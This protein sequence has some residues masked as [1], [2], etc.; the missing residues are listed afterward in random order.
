MRIQQ[1]A[2]EGKFNY[3]VVY[4]PPARDCV[5]IE[6]LTANVDAFNTGEGLNIL[7]PG[8]SIDGTITVSLT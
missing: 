8:H 4:T 3:L 2:G 6:A 7:A 1:E 5:A